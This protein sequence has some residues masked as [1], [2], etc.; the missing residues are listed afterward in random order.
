MNTVIKDLKTHDCI[1]GHGILYHWFVI[2][3]VGVRHYI[4][5]DNRFLLVAI[6]T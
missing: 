4:T 3:L 1:S 5:F 2:A 6:E